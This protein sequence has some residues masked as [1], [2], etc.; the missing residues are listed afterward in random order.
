MYIYSGSSNL[1]NLNTLI[2]QTPKVTVL[3]KYF[4]ITVCSIRVY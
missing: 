2:I 3:L 4:V 1:D